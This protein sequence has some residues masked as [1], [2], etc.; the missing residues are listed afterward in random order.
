MLSDGAADELAELDSS[1]LVA[2]ADVLPLVDSEVV[3]EVVKLSVAEVI[4]EVSVRVVRTVPEDVAEPVE[5]AEPVTEPTAV[6]VAPWMPKLGEKLMLEA[7]VSST[8]SML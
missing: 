1:E 5:V 4:D 2:L 6:P 8:I 7:F 3:T